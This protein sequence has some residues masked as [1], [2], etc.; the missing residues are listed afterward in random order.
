MYKLTIHEVTRSES[1]CH[2]CHYGHYSIKMPSWHISPINDVENIN[3]IVVIIPNKIITIF[4]FAQHQM[5]KEE[6]GI[7]CQI[8][9]FLPQE[10]VLTET[11]ME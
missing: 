4:L 2:F 10:A 1:H 7:F 3:R 6:L 11:F 8:T 5:E 9:R